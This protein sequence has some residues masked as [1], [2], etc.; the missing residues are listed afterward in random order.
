MI[1]TENY[2]LTQP[3]YTFNYYYPKLNA[4]FC[5][6]PATGGIFLS[7][8]LYMREHNLSEEDV[9]RS[10][11]FFSVNEKQQKVRITDL[12]K[13]EDA[14]IFSFVR[15]PI[16][17]M[18][19]LFKRFR[20]QVPKEEMHWQHMIP[21]EG[22]ETF[23]KFINNICKWTDI[24]NDVHLVSQHNLLTYNGVMRQDYV[25][26]TESFHDNV[27]EVC[28]KINIKPPSFQKVN[29]SKDI[30][31]EVSSLSSEKIFCRYYKDY[32]LLSLLGH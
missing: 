24:V 16:D 8:L 28:D 27:L 20:L 7:R 25:G 17:R 19:S 14:Y 4:V 15:D 31:I 10:W 30:D 6:I 11:Q 32:E 9:P 3:N 18:L 29:H 2:K 12:H 23:D 22:P 21:N 5:H 26:R 1:D 13:Y